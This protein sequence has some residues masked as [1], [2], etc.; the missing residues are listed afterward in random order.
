MHF[1]KK[2]EDRKTY[3]PKRCVKSKNQKELNCP[4][5]CWNVDIDFQSSLSYCLSHL[6]Q[7]PGVQFSCHWFWAGITWGSRIY[8]W[9]EFKIFLL[10]SQ[11]LNQGYRTQSAVLI[12]GRTVVELIPLLAQCEIQRAHSGLNSAW[13]IHFHRWLPL[14]QMMC[15]TLLKYII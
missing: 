12:T 7:L 9:F 5:N 3:L 6:V 11:T 10:V 15:Y 8:N 14:H 2:Q 4:N 13:R 1:R